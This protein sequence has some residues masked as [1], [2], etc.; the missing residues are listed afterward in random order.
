MQRPQRL[1]L[2]DD[3]PG[4]LRALG[5]LL[6]TMHFEVLSFNSGRDAIK[7]ICEEPAIDLVVTDLRMPDLDGLQ[8]L[9][10]VQRLCPELP[11]I[12]MSG[13]ACQ[14]DIQGLQN[15]GAKG[16]LPKPF[17]PS[18]FKTALQNAALEMGAPKTNGVS[19][20]L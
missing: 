2:I 18:Q 19:Y 6:Q 9:K 14:S 4:V 20:K 8:V 11:V 10:L 16:F 15:H 12:V 7:L 17:T 1:V 3:E 5:L 13:H